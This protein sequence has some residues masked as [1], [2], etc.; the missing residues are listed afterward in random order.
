M[1]P[2]KDIA[3]ARRE[4]RRPLRHETATWQT[5]ALGTFGMSLAVNLST[6]GAHELERQAWADREAR[7]QTDLQNAEQVRDHAVQELGVLAAWVSREQ[8]AREE[9]A[10]AYETAAKE[11]KDYASVLARAP[12][13]TFGQG[14]C[15]YCGHCKPCPAGIDIAM[16][17]KLYD[18]ALMQ[19]ELPASLK[20]HYDQLSANAD[21]C[22]G[23]KSCESRCPFGVKIAD[24]MAEAV[25][26]FQLAPFFA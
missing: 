5:V 2:T 7:Y 20:A 15:T 16:V 21:A 1:T 18:L 24:R 25:R 13:H 23:C 26:L 17:N 11:E 6:F 22:I 4:S 12:R 19:E 8:Q 3:H 14:E 9:Q 10:A